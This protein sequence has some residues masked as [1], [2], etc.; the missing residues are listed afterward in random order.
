MVKILFVEADRPEEYNCS[1][2]R[3]Q[4]P[5][6]SLK[7]AGIPVEVIRIEDWTSRT[8][9]ADRLSEEADLIFV[10][11]NLF[12]NALN[13]VIHWKSK[14][15]AVV[16][17]LDDAYEFM[18]EA[19]GSPSFNFWIKGRAY[20]QDGT[21]QELNPRPLSMLQWGVKLCGQLSSP[22]KI[23]CSDW[24]EK[25]KTY[26]F[27]NYID[28]ELY[29][30]YPVYHPDGIYFGW[31]GSMTHLQSWK[32]SGIMRAL[33]Q[34]FKERKDCYLIVIGDERVTKAI[35]VPPSQKV[36]RD[37]VPHSLFPRELSRFDIGLA[38]LFGE[39]DR[40]RSWIK[41]LEFTT[42]GIP[43]IGSDMEPNQE[44]E[45]GLL[46]KNTPESWYENMTFAIN[47]LESMK[48]IAASNQKIGL[49]NSVYNRVDT[50][51]ALFSD[52]IKEC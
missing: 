2:W 25:A 38:P 40:R 52:I 3:C 33:S 34:L 7:R 28:H 22:S 12:T 31:G 1:L 9:E 13:A 18:S 46:A 17:D 8:P 32:E 21:Y 47:N 15:K 50:L 5:A 36:H 20:N 39:Y 30:T 49:E 10:Q 45:T 44:L 19:T 24:S 37:W 35:P 43:W 51:M 4:Y 23:I 41:S 16:V 48:Q 29:H 42:M 26:M 27:P 14:G 11:R 6:R